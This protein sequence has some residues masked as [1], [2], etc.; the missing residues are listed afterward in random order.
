MCN[1]RK[2]FD[3]FKKK[4]LVLLELFISELLKQVPEKS[5]ETMIF[6]LSSN[7]LIDAEGK[8]LKEKFKLGPKNGCILTLGSHYEFQSWISRIV[9]L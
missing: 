3:S 7:T 9:F 8:D 2:S 6:C 4:D 1:S 5:R